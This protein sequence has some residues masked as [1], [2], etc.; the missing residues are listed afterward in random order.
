MSPPSADAPIPHPSAEI[1]RQTDAYFLRTR[2]I[3]SR[4]GDESA[5]YVVFMRRPLVFTPRL[6]IGWLEAQARARGV[7]VAIELLHQEGDWVGAGEP[8]FTYTGSLAGLVDL[9]TQLLQKVGP[10][11]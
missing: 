7:D 9:E 2:E 5:T 1:E 10:P 4:F 3:V 8:L 11:C 6:A